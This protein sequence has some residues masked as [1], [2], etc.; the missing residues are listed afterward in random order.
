MGP[1]LLS[2]ATVP[3]SGSS[4][5]HLAPDSAFLGCSSQLLVLFPIISETKSNPLQDLIMCQKVLLKIYYKSH[6]L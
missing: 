5:T 1:E 6:L 3:E 2:F 4:Q